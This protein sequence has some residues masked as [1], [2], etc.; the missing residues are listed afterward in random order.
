MIPFLNILYVEI[1]CNFFYPEKQLINLSNSPAYP[2]MTFYLYVMRVSIETLTIE[3]SLLSLKG[4]FISAT[5]LRIFKE[6]VAR[7]HLSNLIQSYSALSKLYTVLDSLRVDFYFYPCKISASNRNKHR[8][9]N[10]CI[11]AFG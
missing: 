6:I 8:R 5:S 3:M 11:Y 1:I 2:F 4:M 9:Y 10:K 7:V